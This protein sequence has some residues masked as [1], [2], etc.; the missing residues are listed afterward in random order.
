M[1][2]DGPKITLKRSI[3][4]RL[5]SLTKLDQSGKFLSILFLF[6]LVMTKK[7]SSCFDWKYVIQNCLK[8]C[9]SELESWQY[10]IQKMKPTSREIRWQ[11]VSMSLVL[12][13]SSFWDG[14]CFIYLNW[15]FVT[16][17]RNPTIE[18]G[19]QLNS[20]FRY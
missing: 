11:K 6:L 13:F 17:N 18:Q 10:P 12:S 4:P 14:S 8:Q 16:Y 5:S 3:D 15:G 2:W 1:T 7:F 9:S 19:S 20:Y